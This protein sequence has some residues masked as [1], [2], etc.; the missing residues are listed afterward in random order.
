[1]LRWHHALKTPLV[2]YVVTC[3]FSTLIKDQN[4]TNTHVPVVAVPGVK[5]AFANIGFV[6]LPP[7]VIV[8]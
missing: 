5:Y 4:I 8:L 6:R 1:M 2:V 3:I 7:P